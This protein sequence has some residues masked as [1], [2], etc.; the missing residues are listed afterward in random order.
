MSTEK[1]LREIREELG[2]IRRAVNGGGNDKWFV[3]LVIIVQGLVAGAISAYYLTSEAGWPVIPAYSLVYG[4]LTVLFFLGLKR[5]L[6]LYI[7]NAHFC[8]YWGLLTWGCA[9]SLGPVVSWTLGIV[10]FIFTL[11]LFSLN[12]L[13]PWYWRRK[14]RK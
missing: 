1:E 14:S 10:V 6:P 3:F 2:S 4:V 9:E 13:Y 11:V 12:H 7:F 8:F 5:P